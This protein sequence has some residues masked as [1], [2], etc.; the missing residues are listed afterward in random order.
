MTK[1]VAREA[2]VAIKAIQI[3]RMML[4]EHLKH[5]DFLVKFVADPAH[6]C[7][8]MSVENQVRIANATIAFLKEVDA[9]NRSE[10]RRRSRTFVNPDD[11]EELP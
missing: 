3:A 2:R 8:T 7:D 1:K 11:H 4:T 10:A 6:F 9:A 5:Y